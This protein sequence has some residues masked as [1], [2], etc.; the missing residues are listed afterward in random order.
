MVIYVIETGQYSDRHVVGVTDNEDKAKEICKAINDSRLIFNNSTTY[1]P[2]DTDQF[3]TQKLRYTV[4]FNV[5]DS[6][7]CEYDDYGVYDFY[8]ENIME[9]P[10]FFIIYA[11]TP[12]QAIK[13]A[14]DMRAEAEAERNGL[15]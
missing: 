9:Y 4:D 10:G 5:D 14:C 11:D 2:Y 3:Q 7:V 13:I 1:T 15:C 8:Y 6:P 12:E